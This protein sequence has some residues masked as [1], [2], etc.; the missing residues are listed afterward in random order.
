L[1]VPDVVVVTK[2]DIGAPA[3]RARADVEG[4]LTLNAEIDYSPPVVL[5]SAAEHTGLDDLDA[6]VARHRVFLADG[7]RL[8][9]RR[10]RQQRAWVE[11]AI[12]ARFGSAGLAIARRLAP[13][14]NGPFTIERMLS[15]ELSGRLDI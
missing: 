9:R 14:D 6:A 8:E 12:R 5:V 1:E 2:A 7:D 11:E 4:A 10:A 13:R 15:R 3:R